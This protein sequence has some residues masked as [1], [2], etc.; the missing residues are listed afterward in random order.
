MSLLVHTTL[1]GLR[2]VQEEDIFLQ[3]TDR[4]TPEESN[5]LVTVLGSPFHNIVQSYSQL[6]GRIR[7]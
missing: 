6:M 2:V 4:I 1:S 5:I 3:T 7:G